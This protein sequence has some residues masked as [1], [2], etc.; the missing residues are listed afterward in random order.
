M[1]FAGGARRWREPTGGFQAG[2][3]KDAIFTYHRT[4]AIHGW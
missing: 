4:R 1:S 2:R 3:E